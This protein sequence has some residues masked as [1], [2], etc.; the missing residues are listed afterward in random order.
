MASGVLFDIIR[1]I[2][3]LNNGDGFNKNGSIG[4]VALRLK[5]FLDLF[6]SNLF[7]CVEVYLAKSKSKFQ[8][9]FFSFFVSVC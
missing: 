1:S 6:L 8:L 9:L 3:Q 7:R 4:L 5:T 2:G